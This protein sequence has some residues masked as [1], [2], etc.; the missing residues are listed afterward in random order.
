[1]TRHCYKCGWEYK[2][3]GQP[4][5]SET[6]QRCGADLKVCLNCAS[7]DPRAAYQ[8]RDRRAEPVQDK[9]L[10]N[11]CEYFEFAVRV[12]KPDVEEIKREP[13]AREQLRKLLG[14]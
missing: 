12:Y 9:H 3:P 2:L 10:A 5:R 13:A 14:D 11:F 1:M 8:C 4:G 6:C 7:Y